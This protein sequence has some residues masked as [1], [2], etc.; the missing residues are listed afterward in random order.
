MRVRSTPHVHAVSS[1]PY[2]CGSQVYLLPGWHE[3]SRL[4]LAAI[5]RIVPPLAEGETAPDGYIHPGNLHLALLVG[6]LWDDDA[7]ELETPMP[8]DVLALPDQAIVDLALALYR[9]ISSRAARR[10]VRPGELLMAGV[11]AV[12][13]GIDP[14]N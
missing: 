7:L 11:K 3:E 9:E 10:F 1:K 5:N 13:A 2:D 12:Q 14:G 4:M 6:A 8:D